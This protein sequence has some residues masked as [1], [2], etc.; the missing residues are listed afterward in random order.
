[1][2]RTLC[3]HIARLR[4]LPAEMPADDDGVCSSMTRV[5]PTP[6]SRNPVTKGVQDAEPS[7]RMVAE[8][9]LSPIVRNAQVTHSF[10]SRVFG[11][12]KPSGDDMVA[13]MLEAVRRTGDGDMTL[14]S[15]A[16][17]AQAMTLDAIFTDLARRAG[18]NLSGSPEVVDRYVRLALKAQS[19][20]RSTLEALARLHQPREQIVKH[21]H[22]NEG[23][24]A[25]V[26][27]HFHHHAGGQQNGKAN[28]QPHAAGTG[29]AGAGS[30]LPSPD[31]IRNTV[32][33]AGSKRKP[34][35]P[36]ARRKRQ[37]SA[38]R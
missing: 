26:A 15:H 37:R 9:I 31:P 14:V 19:S 13:P 16:L 38:A 2:P 34:A 3:R 17:S 7:M 18:D 4:S 28:G 8:A 32:P 33:S 30:A 12:P 20:C 22:V 11:G 35:M 10:G 23:G 21:V 24:Q 1:M 25:V 6:Q 29:A 36:H 27:D 5:Q